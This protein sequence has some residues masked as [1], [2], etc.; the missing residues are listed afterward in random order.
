MGDF[1]FQ[2]GDKVRDKITGIQGTI[3]SRAD[4]LTSVN[5]YCV[6]TDKPSETW[7]DGERLERVPIEGAAVEQ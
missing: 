6:E 4:Y 1:K 5:R 7:L 3:T 2:L